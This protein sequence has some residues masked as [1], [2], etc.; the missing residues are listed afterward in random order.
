MED[1]EALA[2]STK[3]GKW[4]E[5]NKKVNSKCRGLVIPGL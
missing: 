1:S 2:K 5:S 3:G 4:K